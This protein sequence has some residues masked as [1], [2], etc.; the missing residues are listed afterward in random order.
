MKCIVTLG[1]AKHRRIMRVSDS[2]ARTW[3][4]SGKALYITKT[5]WKKSR[6]SRVKGIEKD[7][8]TMKEESYD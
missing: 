2:E 5:E 4:I 1:D 3:V 7:E 6:S 8:K